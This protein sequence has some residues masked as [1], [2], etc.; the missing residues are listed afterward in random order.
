MSSFTG[1][2]RCRMAASR[3]ASAAIARSGPRHGCRSS[4]PRRSNRWSHASWRPP[5]ERSSCSGDSAVEAPMGNAWTRRSSASIRCATE[6][7]PA[8]RCSTSTL[9][10]SLTSWFGRV[11]QTPWPLIAD[12]RCS[13]RD[14][15]RQA[16]VQEEARDMAA[17]IIG[18]RRSAPRDTAWLKEYLP[19]TA[20]LIAKHG[21]KPLIGGNTTPRLLALEGAGEPPLG[22]VMLEF[23][24][25]E[26]AQ[27]WHDDPDYAPLKQMRQANL[28]MEIFVVENV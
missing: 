13:R 11:N 18:L 1:P 21:G 9:W 28:D 10:R 15:H 2:R 27:A 8:L 16:R 3:R 12:V 14:G 6:N 25:L 22:V 4:P 7:W 20:A 5:T 23:P 19:K 24:S 26:Q 17:Y